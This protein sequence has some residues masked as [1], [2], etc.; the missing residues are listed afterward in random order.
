MMLDHVGR[1]EL[2]QLLRKAIHSTLNDDQVRT[3]DL[4]GRASTKQFAQ[5][6]VQKF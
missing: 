1:S 3:G 6:I 2:A 5:A 4:G